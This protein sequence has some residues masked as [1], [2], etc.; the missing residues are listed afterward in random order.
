[1]REDLREELR[2]V[3]LFTSGIAEMTRNRAED[4]VRDWVRSDVRREQAQAMA[5]DLLEWSKHNRKEMTAFVRAE[6]QTQLTN[7][8]VVTRRD[9]DRLER[10]VATLEDSVRSLAASSARRDTPSR[11]ATAGRKKT[12]RKPTAARARSSG[13]AARS[14]RRQHP[15]PPTPSGEG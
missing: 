3:A 11:K 14:T 2:R 9:F 5:K 7:V 4:L 6:I 15:G 10:R 12:S 1:V 13:G 8:G